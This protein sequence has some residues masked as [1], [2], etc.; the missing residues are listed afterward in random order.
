MGATK[1]LVVGGDLAVS[2]E[3]EKALQGMGMVTERVEVEGGNRYSTAAAIGERMLETHPSNTAIIAGGEALVDSLVAGP[4]S[5]AKGYPLLLVADHVPN[6][7][8]DFIA[9]NNIEHLVVVGG[10]AVVSKEVVS[11]LEVIVP[12]SVTRVAGDQTYGENRYGT[13][14][15]F[16]R[17]YFEEK[18]SVALVNGRSFVDAVAASVLGLPILYVETEE[19]RIDVESILTGKKDFRAVGGPAVICDTVITKAVKVVNGNEESKNPEEPDDPEE[20]E[21]PEPEPYDPPEDPR[22]ILPELPEG[23]NV[24]VTEYSLSMEEMLDLQMTRN[25][26]TDLYGGGWKSAKP[27][28]VQ[29][30]LE[31]RNFTHLLNVENRIVVTT[32]ILNVRKGPS[33]D[34][35]ILTKISLGQEFEYTRTTEPGDGYTWYEIDIKGL[36]TEEDTGWV[37]GDLVKKVEME[38]DEIPSSFYQFLILSGQSGAKA[39]DLNTILKDKGVLDGTGSFFMDAGEQ[40]NINEIYLVSHA[41]LET[42]NGRSTLARGVLVEE[43]A[44]IPLEEPKVVYNMFG[45]GAFDSDP[46]GYGAE[47]AYHQGWFSYEEAIIGGSEWIAN[48]YVNHETYNQD[49]LYKMRW[50]PERPG[51]HQYATDI[52]WAVKQTSRIKALYNLCENYSLRFDVP[53]YQSKD[54]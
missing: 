14:V 53:D 3:V 40:F 13:S 29:Y 27:E 7:T 1:A 35:D 21:E 22:P 46:I 16:Y 20:P 6:A 50:N 52:G 2:A 54:E 51:I 4:L 9:T 49:T 36:S 41:L 30:Y 19:L 37:R 43:V 47:Y 31:P 45:I 44:G 38:K 34:Y 25:P 8:R 39:K 18:D 24:S 33:T 23:M 17:N 48:R 10:E 15:N 28:D 32:S 11:E 26:Q 5:N 42:G 12:G